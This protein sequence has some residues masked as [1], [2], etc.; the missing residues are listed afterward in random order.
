MTYGAKQYYINRNNSNNVSD[1]SD[2]FQHCMSRKSIFSNVN[3]CFNLVSFNL[4]VL[5]C[6]YNI[7]FNLWDINAWPPVNQFFSN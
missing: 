1:K 5:Y 6:I 2:K 7:Y 3:F 4:I